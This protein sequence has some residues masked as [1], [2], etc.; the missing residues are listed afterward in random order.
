MM[1]DR[2]TGATVGRNTSKRLRD[3][4]DSGIGVRIA[5]GFIDSM[6]VS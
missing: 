5:D 4:N 3:H 6:I 1:S 2:T